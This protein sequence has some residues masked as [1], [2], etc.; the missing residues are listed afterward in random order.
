M[1]KRFLV[2]IA[3]LT[4]GFFIVGCADGDKS[5][6]TV[7]PNPDVFA[8]TGSIS[9]V[10]FDI[11]SNAPVQ[12]AVVSVAYAGKTHSVTTGTT[13]SFSFNDVPAIEQNGSTN[14]WE[15]ENDVDYPV[16]CDLTGKNIKVAGVAT[17]YGYAVIN[18]VEV[19]YSELQDGN[20]Y[21]LGNNDHQTEAGSGASTPV[22]K[23]AA[24]THF[25]VGP[26]TSSISG[27]VFDVTTGLVGVPATVQLYWNGNFVATTTA[28]AA[29]VFSFTGI[30]AS[31]LSEKSYSAYSLQVSV[32]GWDVVEGGEKVSD[33]PD[34]CGFLNVI[35][36]VPC[37]G[38][39]TGIKVYLAYN[40]DKDT[41]AP[42]ITSIVVP[43][44]TAAADGGSIWGDVIDY[45]ATTVTP[46]AALVV[47]FSEAMNRKLTTRNALK[48]VSEYTGTLTSA[49]TNGQTVS[50]TEVDIIKSWA[51]AWNSAG[52]TFTIIPTF[53]TAV[54]LAGTTHG[55]AWAGGTVAYTDG[56]MH[57]R[58]SGAGSGIHLTDLAGN[59]WKTASNIDSA[60]EE[61][62]DTF[63][64]P[65]PD[66]S[67]SNHW[68]FWIGQG[69]T[70][71][72][73]YDI[74]GYGG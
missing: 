67:L 29:G 34:D 69:N 44:G 39:L 72:D 45:S 57:L 16:T 6:S 21:D 24:T 38:A 41:T 46:F 35:C 3:L 66:P 40:P 8:P 71:A 48:L 22:N 19:V 2:L 20:N 63:I 5:V 64:V 32:P 15:N 7:N 43:G 9:G 54:E 49:G 37:K 50:L 73:F 55:G 18:E 58:F 74:Y 26:L 52:T 68:W 59:V 65:E 10:V 70:R 47:N 23:L 33:L 36:A 17:T 11:C 62:Q 13:G 60:G 14:Y 53:Y 28:S 31:S 42:Y 4:L 1:Y 51:L 25:D 56:F 27:T 30:M 61:Y 12:G